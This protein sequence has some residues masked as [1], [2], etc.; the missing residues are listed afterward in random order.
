MSQQPPPFPGS[1]NTGAAGVQPGTF[2]CPKCRGTMRTY[3][4]NGVHIEQ[5]DQCRGLFLDFGEL[6][7]LTQLENRFVAQPPPAQ[8][9][10]GP[11]WGSR[12]GHQYHKK[13][14]AGLFFSS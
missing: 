3:N 9:Q 2:V 13:G 12:G 11:A 4:R 8:Y 14:L 6:E 1:D 5:C 10:A 7:H